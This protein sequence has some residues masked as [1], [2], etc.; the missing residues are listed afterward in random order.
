MAITTDRLRRLLALASPEWRRANADTEEWASATCNAAHAELAT[1][2]VDLGRE[3]LELREQLEDTRT[4]QE[5]IDDE[6]E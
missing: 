5:C 6:C 2:Y 4:A 1:M 3:L